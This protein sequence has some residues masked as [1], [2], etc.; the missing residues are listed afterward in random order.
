MFG[1]KRRRRDGRAQLGTKCE[2]W[3]DF[4]PW[5]RSLKAWSSLHR[6]ASVF[7]STGKGRSDDRLGVIRIEGM[8]PR[9]RVAVR[10]ALFSITVAFIA[11]DS[12]SLVRNGS[13][14]AT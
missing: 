7:L 2:G 10:D 1:A 9:N 4:L 5:E 12:A 6:W 3:Q 8:D 13:D 11:N 14:A